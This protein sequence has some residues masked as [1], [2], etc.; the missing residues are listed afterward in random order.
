MCDQSDKTE[1]T[2]NLEEDAT[3]ENNYFAK[4]S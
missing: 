2:K 4:M 3:S 1:P